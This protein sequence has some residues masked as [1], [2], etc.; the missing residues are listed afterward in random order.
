MLTFTVLRDSA[1]C[2]DVLRQDFYSKAVHLLSA[3]LCTDHVNVL[4]WDQTHHVSKK[5]LK[6]KPSHLQRGRQCRFCLW[7]PGAGFLLSEP[8][9]GDSRDEGGCSLTGAFAPFRIKG[10]ED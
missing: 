2:G 6:E 4:G 9:Q 3:I 7:Q 8:P 5:I 1:T 10:E